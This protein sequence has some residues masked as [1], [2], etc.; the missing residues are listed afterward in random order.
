MTPTSH[1]RFGAGD[2]LAVVEQ[3]R[4]CALAVAVERDLHTVVADHRDLFAGRPFDPALVSG[5]AM[6]VAF[7]APEYTAEQLRVTARTVLWVFAA[8]WQIDYLARTADDVRE[9]T[10]ACLA[11]ADAGPSSARHPLARLLGGIR[12]E[13]SAAPA[14]AVVEPVWRDEVGRMF[15]AMSREWRWKTTRGTGPTGPT[16]DDYLDI[17][18]NTAAVLVSVTHWAAVGDQDCLDHLDALRVTARATQRAIRL[19][20]DLATYRR[21]LQWGDLNAL[22]LAGATDV[23][24]RLTRIV[25]ESREL[26]RPLERSCPRQAAFLSRQIAFTSGFYRVSDFW[27]SL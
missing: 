2:Q 25:E 11:A 20:N 16:L 26:L 8:D 17:A 14:F 23:T 22:M 10:A 18:D 12:D 13:L 5:I 9:V 3:A 4:I 7:T 21:D 24:A 6:S 19:I 15:A 27:G 1:V